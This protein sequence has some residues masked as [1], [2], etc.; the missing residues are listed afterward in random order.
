H[1]L[2]QHAHEIDSVPSLAGCSGI[3]RDLCILGLSGRV[4]PQTLTELLT[5]LASSFKSLPSP[6]AR[7]SEE[8]PLHRQE[9]CLNRELV[10]IVTEDPPVCVVNVPPWRITTRDNR[11]KVVRIPDGESPPVHVGTVAQGRFSRLC[12]DLGQQRVLAS[13]PSWI[14][15]VE[16]SES[17]RGV[18]SAQF[19]RGLRDALGA[20]GYIGGPELLLPPYFKEAI[21]ALR[22]KNPASLVDCQT[23]G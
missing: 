5:T 13:L 22:S 17:T 14:Q 7:P 2:V 12:D 15:R 10:H 21:A 9:L 8:H 19:W 11:S 16:K 23:S 18:A 1:C 3:V 4:P 20:S 6:D